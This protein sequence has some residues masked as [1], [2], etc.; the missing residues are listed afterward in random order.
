MEK[1]FGRARAKILGRRLDDLRAAGSLEDMRYL[2]G[3]CHEYKKSDK[4]T[5]DLDGGWRL[6]FRASQEPIPVLP[7]GASLDWSRVTEIEIT[8]VKDPHGKKK[9]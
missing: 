4:L 7:D 6:F 3:D 9:K 5:L 8:D 2:P 1:K